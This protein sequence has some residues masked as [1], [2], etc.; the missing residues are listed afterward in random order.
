[1]AAVEQGG[2]YLKVRD[3]EVKVAERGGWRKISL[4]HDDDDEVCVDR[5]WVDWRGHS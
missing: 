2:P 3:S 5:W 1:M 4:S